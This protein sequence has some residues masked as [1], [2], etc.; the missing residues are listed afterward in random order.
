MKRSLPIGLIFLGTLLSVGSL[1]WLY[2]G[3]PTN[4][5]ESIPSL[6]DQLGGLSRTDYRTGTQALA[7]FENLHGKQ[8]PLTSGAIGTYG[9]Q[10]ITVWAA[11]T[12]SDSIASQM[13]EAMLERIAEGNSPF[14]PLTQINNNNR[15][16]YVLEGMGQRH[17]YFQ[18][19]NLVIWVAV[20]PALADTVIQQ[21][22]EAYP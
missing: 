21:I 16:V 9:D 12:S 10:Q 22:L 14:T 17:F 2:L 13:V 7:E 6:P 3:N 20:E 11:A 8:F 15:L 19:K 4:T 5:A 18:A 1:G